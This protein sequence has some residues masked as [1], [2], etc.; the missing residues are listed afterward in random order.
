[1]SSTANAAAIRRDI[2]TLLRPPRRIR[3]SDAVAESMYVVHGNGTKTLW[4]PDTAPYM[5]EP[6]DCLG[7]RMYDAVVF[8]GPARTGEG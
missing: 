5:I 1:M 3:V 7:S 2:A 8:V 4:D 6:M